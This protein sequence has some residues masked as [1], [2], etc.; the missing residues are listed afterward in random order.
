[1]EFFDYGVRRNVYTKIVEKDSHIR[2][3]N[4]IIILLVIITMLILRVTPLK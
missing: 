2:V 4:V 3:K 1:M